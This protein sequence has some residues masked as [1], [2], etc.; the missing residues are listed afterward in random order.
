MSKFAIGL[1]YGTE[2]GRAVVVDVGTGRQVG[3][4]VYRYADGVISEHLPGSSTRLEP[5]TALQN[6][7]D[8]VET[9]KQAVPEAL[10]QAGVRAEDVI[11]IGVDF[12][13]CTILPVR[14]DAT[15]LRALPGWKGN[16]HAWVKLWKH[17]AAQPEADRINQVARERQEAWLPLYGGI[18]SSE[19]FHSK[20]LQILNDSPDA[21][22]AA[23]KI[24]EAGDWIVWQM[25]GVMKRNACAAGYKGLWVKGRGY[26][27]NEF[28]RALDPRLDRLNE[29][30]LAGDIVPPGTPVGFLTR[31]AAKW[32]G[33]RPGIAVAAPIIDAHAAV[34]GAG[35][36]EPGRMVLILGTS[37]C[38]MILDRAHHPVPGISGVVEDGILPGLFGYEAGQAGVGDMFQWFVEHALPAAYE[39]RAAERGLGVYQLLE[40]E[41]AQLKPG[42]SGLLALDW[43]NG[44]RT[45]LVDAT[46]GG[47]LVGASLSTRARDIY[48]ALVEATAFGTRMIIDTFEENGVSVNK[49]V[50]CGGLAERNKLL[51]QIYADVTGRELIEAGAAQTSAH[52]AAMFGACAAGRV[53]GGYDAIAQAAKVMAPTKET[54]YRPNPENH[55]VYQELSAEYRRL[56]EYF[57]RGTNDVMKH[58]RA[59]RHAVAAPVG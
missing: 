24:V 4:A 56:H 28:L 38:H 46:L 8:Y 17:H 52:G 41:A 25:T 6:P 53:A 43:W 55:A 59:I 37:T 16:P 14:A 20:T 18:V 51:L 39:K 42:E 19:W 45:P 21:F 26:P 15:P 12:T 9:L 31:E 30:K 23:D 35:V 1:D 27:S 29:T 48:R 54:S 11:G 13:A 5:D 47:M 2:S 36:T 57:G 34:P 50:A 3:S 22:A 40:E 10:A 33:L 58:L 49:M 7:T 32:M 44:C